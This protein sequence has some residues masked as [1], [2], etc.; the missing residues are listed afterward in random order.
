MRNVVMQVKETDPE[1]LLKHLTISS[2][3]DRPLT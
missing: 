2:L 3:F 1:L